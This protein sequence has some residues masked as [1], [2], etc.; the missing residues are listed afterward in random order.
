MTY[1]GRTTPIHGCLM[2]PAKMVLGRAT[3]LDNCEN[4]NAN[5]MRPIYF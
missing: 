2:V 3:G 1:F 4:D 5:E